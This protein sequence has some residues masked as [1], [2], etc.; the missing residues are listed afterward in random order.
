EKAGWAALAALDGC[1]NCPP[2]Y[3]LDY[4]DRRQSPELHASTIKSFAKSFDVQYVR[5][6]IN[7]YQ[8]ALARDAELR[9]AARELRFVIDEWMTDDRKNTAEFGIPNLA[10]WMRDGMFHVPAATHQDRDYGAELLG[11][12]IRYLNKPNDLPM[13]LWLALGMMETVWE[14]FASAGPVY[15][16]CRAEWTPEYLFVKPLR[17]DLSQVG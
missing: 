8:K 5:V 7:A 10:R 14:Q 6:E 12:L 3:V 4:G 13:A 15:L 2:S 1:V 17:I 11:S 9:E 16:P